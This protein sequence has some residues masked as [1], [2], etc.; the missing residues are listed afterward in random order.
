MEILLKLI[1]TKI[2]KIHNFLVW[3]FSLLVWII[4]FMIA[5]ITLLVSRKTLGEYFIEYN[6]NSQPLSNQFNNN[7]QMYLMDDYTSN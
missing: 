4:Y 2:E 3:N 7:F 5:H 6:C 1:I